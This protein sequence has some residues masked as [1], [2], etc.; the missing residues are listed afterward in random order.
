[1]VSCHRI[2]K[3]SKAVISR[4]PDLSEDAASCWEQ[5]VIRKTAAMSDASSPS[6]ACV[7]SETSDSE[8][9]AAVCRKR[10]AAAA[11]AAAASTS[12]S[13]DGKTG[14]P[15]A[16]QGPILGDASEGT[17]P[18]D[19]GQPPTLQVDSVAAWALRR[20]SEDGYL[21]RIGKR[22]FDIGSLCSGMGTEMVAAL[23]HSVACVIG[24]YQ[25]TGPRVVE[26]S[27]TP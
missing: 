12:G 6:P 27:T 1:M 10:P 4:P 18:R 19:R 23:G 16:K 26:A 8:P 11:A 9:A 24:R 3:C 21:T 22:R 15:P 25:N 5:R 17:S 14:A 20:L 13:D 2:K 7:V